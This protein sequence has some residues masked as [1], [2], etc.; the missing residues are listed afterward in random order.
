VA[1]QML[2]V[3]KASVLCREHQNFTQSSVSI[4]EEAESV[5]YKH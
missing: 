5:F 3:S 4:T 1:R 2:C